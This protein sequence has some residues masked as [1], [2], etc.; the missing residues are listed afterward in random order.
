MRELKGRHILDLPHSYV[1]VDVETTGLDPSKDQLI[2]VAALK[3]TDGNVSDS[4]STLIN[5]GVEISSFITKLTGI[6]N[7]DLATAPSP[8]SVLPDLYNF[9]GEDIIVG[10]NVNFDINFLYDNFEH[11]ISKPF[12]NYFADT[13]RLSKKYYKSAPSYKLSD[14]ADFLGITVEKSHRAL[15]D[16][17]T[18]NSL[19][20]KLLEI[21]MNP[22]DTEQILLDSLTF[23]ES[24]PFFGKRIAVKGSPQIY[25]YAFMKEVASK[26]HAKLSDVFYSSCDYIIFGKHTYS[27]YQKGDFSEK[28]EKA[29]RLSA[30]GTL[31]ILSEEQWCEMLGLP[32]PEEFSKPSHRS[33]SAKDIT[34]DKTD[35]DETHPLFGK[36]CV[37]TGALE[38]MQRK[39]AMQIVVDLGG[40]VGNSVTKKTNYLILGNNDYCPLIKDGK[41]SKQKKA[42]DLKLSGCDIEIISEN[43]FYDMISEE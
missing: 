6:T 42:E 22:A 21:S 13:M 10:H 25:S 16:C 35:F 18:T 23:D 1:V 26:C 19:Y 32:V 28:M 3:I 40:Q 43:V 14:L 12:C 9:L 34:T 5:P 38:K 17:I 24:N 20:Q 41:S 37:F 7:Q 2:E 4:Y 39:E 8:E 31:T 33:A 36:L 27:K 29:D 11:Y 30:A 15:D